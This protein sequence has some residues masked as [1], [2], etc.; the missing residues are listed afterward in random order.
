MATGRLPTAPAAAPSMILVALGGNLP[1]PE[2][3][4]PERALAEALRRLEARGARTIARSRFW[5]SAPVPP[6]DQ[7]DYVNAAA[8][9]E[10]TLAPEALLAAMLEVERELGRVR[11]ER[12][13]ARTL[14]LDLL[15]YRN[16]VRRS[17]DLTLPHP[18]LAERAFVL[19]PLAEIAADWRHPVLGLTV[20]EMLARLP[21]AALAAVRP[22]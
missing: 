15:A 8:R 12:W 5:R 19:V 3:G 13:G 11:R 20:A 7:P 22:A 6:S 18:R 10:T 4:P 2:F 16:V 17:R 21:E 14:D 1:T 9:L